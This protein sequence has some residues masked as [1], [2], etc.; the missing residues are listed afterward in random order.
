MLGTGLA[1]SINSAIL[2]AKYRQRLQRWRQLRGRLVS[3]L[4]RARS[5]VIA[6][7]EQSADLRQAR[8]RWRNSQYDYTTRPQFLRGKRVADG[9]TELLSVAE[10]VLR[11]LYSLQ[12][13]LDNVCANATS[14]DCGDRDSHSTCVCLWVPA[15][16]AGVRLYVDNEFA[17]RRPC[18]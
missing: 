1:L 5:E 7:F 10:V 4:E 3:L 8:D 13:R 14:I 16:P 15:C 18:D 12:V 6:W 9:F 11:A 17:A 2:C